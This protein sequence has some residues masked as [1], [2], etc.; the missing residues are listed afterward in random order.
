MKPIVASHTFLD[1]FERCPKQAWHKFVAKD[2][3]FIETEA[4][5]WGIRVHDALER[6]VRDKT[7]LPEGMGSYEKFAQALDYRP[8]HVET[9]LGMTVG[10]KGTGF[11]SP[12]VWCR[13]KVDVATTQGSVCVILDW[14]TGKPREDEAELE[15]FAYLLRANND[16]LQYFKGR[17]VWLKEDRLGQEHDLDPDA[18][19]AKD[20]RIMDQVETLQKHGV[21][22][23]AH[24]NGLCSNYC[25]VMSCPHNGRK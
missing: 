4:M 20:K 9:K 5:K 25:D 13:G 18:R 23:P 10:G 6:R 15:R 7:P 24:E 14:K 11:F 21:A 16:D 22:W 2:L 3:P 19:L 12:N 8:C 17:Y 1:T